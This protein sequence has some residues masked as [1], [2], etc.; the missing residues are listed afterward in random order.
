MKIFIPLFV[1]AF[2]LSALSQATM[3]CTDAL[4]LNFQ[5]EVAPDHQHSHR[6]TD[7]ACVNFQQF[8]LPNHRHLHRNT[9]VTSPNFLQFVPEKKRVRR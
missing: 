1:L 6:D 5:E 9:N 3:R 7:A 8:V 4:C 2:A